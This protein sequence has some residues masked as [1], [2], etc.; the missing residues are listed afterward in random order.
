MKLKVIV[1]ETDGG[2]YWAEVPGIPGCAT[3]GDTIE[4]LRKNL[5]EAIEGCLAV[6]VD[7][8]QGT[9]GKGRIMEITV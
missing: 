4:E 5:C 7:P 8:S 1:H 3:Q 9:A 2:G 6:E